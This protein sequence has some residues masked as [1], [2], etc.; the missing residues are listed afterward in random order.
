[1]IAVKTLALVSAA[2]IGIAQAIPIEAG[3]KLGNLGASAI[4]GVVCLA[5]IYALVRLYRDKEKDV[6]E[7]RKAHS[8]YTDK[9]IEMIEEN[10]KASQQHADNAK[11]MAGVL[12]EVKDAVVTCKKQ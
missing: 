10:T 2:G 3:K 5:S 7:S 11:E 1:M 8:E 6:I 4:L 12:V 9:L